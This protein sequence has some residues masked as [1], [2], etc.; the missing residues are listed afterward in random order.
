MH[1]SPWCKLEAAPHKIDVSLRPFLG[2]LW[3]INDLEWLEVHKPEKQ[4]L[5]DEDVQVLVESLK[6]LRHDNLT[7]DPDVKIFI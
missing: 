7:N 4:A 5:E 1:I 6:P 3:P 2:K